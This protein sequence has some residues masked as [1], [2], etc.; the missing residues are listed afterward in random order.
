MQLTKRLLYGY[1]ESNLTPQGIILSDGLIASPSSV[2]LNGKV[3][4][5]TPPE[6]DP[7][8]AM[9]TGRGWEEWT[10]DIWT[11]FEVVSP[12]PGTLYVLCTDHE[13]ILILGTGNTVLPVPDSIKSY[14][15]ALGIQ[16][17]V[18]NTRNACSTYN[19][20]SEEGRPV[21]AAVLPMS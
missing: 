10:A 15:N 13:E 9:P 2:F 11:L 6:I 14:L 12:R 5:W 18:Q 1:V 8:M 16:L 3:F 17:D 21:A 7:M 20:L 4:T 19:L